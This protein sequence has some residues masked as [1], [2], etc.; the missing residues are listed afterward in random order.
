[1]AGQVQIKDKTVLDALRK[2]EKTQLAPA[3][4]TI[5]QRWT[6]RTMLAFD[7]QRSPGGAPWPKLKTRVGQ[8]LRHTGRLR[9]S[10]PASTRTG[11]DFVELGTNVEYAAIHQFGYHGPMAV[12][13]H[14]RK[15]TKAWGKPIAPKTVNVKA[16][17][18]Q[19]NIPAR[20]FFPTKTLPAAWKQDVLTTVKQIM[21]FP[22]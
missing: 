18:R 22:D 3:M 12:P 10:I 16:H 14:T 5:G 21:G 8:A 17:T 15:I 2:L 1:M 13:A 11:E 7:S 6:S 4:A 19:A 9:S 20:P